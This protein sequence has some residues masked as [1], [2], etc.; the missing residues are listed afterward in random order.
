MIDWFMRGFI[1]GL[2]LPV[3]LNK[4]LIKTTRDLQHAPLQKQSK[5]L[6][7]SIIVSKGLWLY[8]G[9]YAGL[10]LAGFVTTVN[11]K[12]KAGFAANPSP[13]TKQA[14]MELDVFTK[15]Y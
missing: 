3:L 6:R 10:T 14:S 8:A 11:H 4:S 1:P 12:D 9:I 5:R 15:V 7:I 13:S 2:P